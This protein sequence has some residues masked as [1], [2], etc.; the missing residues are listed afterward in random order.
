MTIRSALLAHGV[1]ALLLS[2]SA[3]IGAAAPDPTPYVRNDA[4]R[5]ILISPDGQHL[6]ATI[7][8]D[9]RTTLAILRRADLKVTAGINLGPNTDLSEFWWV[10]SERVVASVAQKFGSMDEPR[11]TG[12]MIGMNVD[13][14][15][16]EILIGQRAVTDTVKSRVRAK[17]GDKVAAWMV[18]TL[19]RDDKFAIIATQ[20]FTDDP[21]FKIDRM[22]VYT[23]RRTTI[24]RGPMRHARFQ[25]DNAGIVR[26]A[27]GG[28]TDNNNKLFHRAS[29]ED[30]W[31]LVNEETSSGV[32]EIALG[33]TADNRTAYLL[34]QRREGP[35]HIVSFDTQT[36]ERRTVLQD[37]DTDPSG[38][39]YRQ[40]SE[41]PIGASFMDGKRRVAYFEDT[42]PEAR[43]QRS[44][45][46][47]FAGNAVQVT[48]TT[49]DGRLAL[50]RV[51]S[52]RNPGDF[53]LFDTVAK[54]ADYLLGQRDWFDP[55]SMAE[56]R[57]VSLK[58][59]DGLALHGYLTIP[60]GS[61][62]KN[63]P[64]I[65]MPHGGPFGLFDSWGF[66]P[67]LQMFAAAGYAV[68]QVNFRGS[69]NHGRAFEH[70]GAREW[71]GKMQDDVTDATRWAIAEGIAD[72]KRI[73]IHGASYGG[74]AALMGVVREPDLYRCASGYIG[75][76]D[77]PMMH[78]VGDTEDSGMGRTFLREWIGPPDQLDAVSPV[79][80]ADRIKV[81]VLLAA[82]G[83]DERAP[84]QHTEQM[85]RALK[86]AGVPVETVYYPTE[87][88]GFYKLEHQTEY[89]TKLL[90]FL[91]R[92]LGGVGSDAP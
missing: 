64:L 58:A 23:G 19:P 87:G 1:A 76:Y 4:F 65:V 40:A 84:I 55:D 20:P 60:H 56:L 88:H 91:Q 90:A 29:D 67:E 80:L 11:L 3:A 38:I 62:G 21:W 8:L 9:D 36:G 14:T 82:G 92:H 28:D 57:P 44:L 63:L 31:Q 6:A 13:G 69:G 12:E 51:W 27:Y 71:G 66:D 33:F 72:A 73:C 47:A 16:S 41:I 5:D 83:E 75:V 89:Y 54:K 45:E 42:F 52:D 7:P 74:Y 34:A 24:G 18:D 68:L 78:R 85:E 2:G 46:A 15:R 53:Y 59:R 43:L 77:L 79:N 26:F 86:N 35:D 32:V 37:D 30:E 22:D 25:T 10:N 48:S 50:V 61:D 81:P 39:I 17:K 49:D 70:A